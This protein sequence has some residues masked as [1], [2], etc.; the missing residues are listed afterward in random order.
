MAF[1]DSTLD[2]WEVRASRIGL[3]PEE[4]AEAIRAGLIKARK[5]QL[6]S[7]FPKQVRRKRKAETK[8]R[9]KRVWR[10]Q[11]LDD[12]A[13]QTILAMEAAGMTQAE[14][15]SAVGVSG[16]TVWQ[17]LVKHSAK[18]RRRYGQ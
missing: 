3:S 17:F 11:L 15:A 4:R 5:P 13:R 6:K 2:R 7:D 16:N 12:A 14:M 9:P 18:P 10:F 8:P 1:F